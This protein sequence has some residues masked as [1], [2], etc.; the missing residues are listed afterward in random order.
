MA[1]SGDG[2]A[3]TYIVQEKRVISEIKII[4]N[5]KL[6]S[7]AIRSVLTWREGDTF[8]EE[9]YEEERAA[10]LK[11]YQTKGMPNAAV[12]IVVEETGPSRVRITYMI[13]EGKKAKISAIHFV[14]NDRLSD[15]RLKKGLETKRRWWFLG[16]KYDESSSRPTSRKSSTNTGT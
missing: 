3:V 11:L 9:G 8:V 1:E 12:D 10:V 15:R 13:T 5:D 14:G 16:G 6:K 7:R 2:V 4:G